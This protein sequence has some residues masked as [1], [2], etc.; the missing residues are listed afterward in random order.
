M[1]LL[2][3]WLFLMLH[4]Y[5]LVLNSVL[6]YLKLL[7]FAFSFEILGFSFVYCWF[8]G[9]TDIAYLENNWLPIIIIRLENNSVMVLLL[10]V[11]DTGITFVIV[12]LSVLYL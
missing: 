11:T 4:Y 9:K 7:T 5:Y 10:I 6:R 1:I 8:V 2:Y 12:Y 3:Q